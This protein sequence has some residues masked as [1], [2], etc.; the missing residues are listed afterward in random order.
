[1]IALI[2]AAAKPWLK[3]LNVWLLVAIAGLIVVIWVGHGKLQE[4]KAQLAK[5][6]GQAQTAT[7]TVASATET[8]KA[9]RQAEAE[10]TLPA[11]KQAILDLC[12]RSASCRERGQR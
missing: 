3:S 8:A 5:A 11:D 10:T 6:E 4:R 7:A 2:W 12:R 9:E 1:M